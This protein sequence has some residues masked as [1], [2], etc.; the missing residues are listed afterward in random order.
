L[1]KALQNRLI[2]RL[3]HHASPNILYPILGSCSFLP[4]AGKVAK[5]YPD[6]FQHLVDGAFKHIFGW[7]CDKF[8]PHHRKKALYRHLFSSSSVQNVVVSNEKEISL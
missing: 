8:G 1:I 2:S 4:I 3:V 7:H 6:W 5:H